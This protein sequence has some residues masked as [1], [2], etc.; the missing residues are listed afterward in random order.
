MEW[1]DHEL[2]GPWFLSL[3]FRAHILQMV[4]G[5]I[6]CPSSSETRAYKTRQLEEGCLLMRS[7]LLAG[8]R[9][10]PCPCAAGRGV[11]VCAYF[12]VCVQMSGVYGV[13]CVFMFGCGCSAV[14][15]FMCV[16]W[17]GTSDE[18]ACV[19]DACV[20]CS[21]VCVCMCVREVM[22]SWFVY[23]CVLGCACICM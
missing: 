15:W 12:V 1:E 22:C 18:V 23:I 6:V 17:C 3:P 20:W 10:A 8:T 13:M 14:R 9:L 19:C 4:P 2:G 16:L 5:L 11:C 7:L 21:T